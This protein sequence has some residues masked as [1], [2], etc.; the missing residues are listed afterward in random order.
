MKDLLKRVFLKYVVGYSDPQKYWEMRW[1][2]GLHAEVETAK[3]GKKLA[4]KIRRIMRKH[5]CMNVLEIGCG[6]APLCE[7]PNYL[8]LDFSSV[9]LTQSGL[10]R[11]IHADVTQKIPLPDKSYD[12]VLCRFVLL[13]IPFPRIECTVKEISR[14]AKKCI[15]L[16]EPWG[17]EQKHSQPHCFTHNLPMLFENY[18][19]GAVVFIA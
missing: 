19:L 17:E 18:F 15:I 3:S 2:L 12:A 9:A 7:L 10:K 11:F 1:R 6:S 13:H 14:V 16:Q 5:E 4:P 8:G